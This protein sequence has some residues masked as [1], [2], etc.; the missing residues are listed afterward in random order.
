LGK[1]INQIERTLST[2]LYLLLSG[3]SSIVIGIRLDGCVA[4]AVYH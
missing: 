1:V 3:M 2:R 4:V